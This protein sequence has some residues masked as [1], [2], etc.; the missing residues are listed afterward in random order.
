M[1]NEK[2]NHQKV[3][4]PMHNNQSGYRKK[5]LN[6][7]DY[8]FQSDVDSESDMKKYK[9]SRITKEN[10]QMKSKTPVKLIENNNQQ[11]VIT[12]NYKFSNKKKEENSNTNTNSKSNYH[13]YNK[14][15][16]TKNH[17]TSPL[18]MKIPNKIE[19]F[20]SGEE[21]SVW[22]NVPKPLE[23]NNKQKNRDL[24]LN[25]NYHNED[26][27]HIQTTTNKKVLSDFEASK[28]IDNIFQQRENLNNN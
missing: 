21:D 10:H 22:N 4:V 5:A 18:K 14:P 25:Y 26:G 9:N 6:N 8:N 19:E 3:P 12:N 20:S 2:E 23:V 28:F 7:Q 11:A 16:A 17:H 27:K 13:S 15:S 24:N 1:I